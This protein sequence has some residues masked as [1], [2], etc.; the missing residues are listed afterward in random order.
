ME[1]L[2]IQH[3]QEV[4][5]FSCYWTPNGPTAA[6]RIE[7]F[8]GFLDGLEGAIKNMETTNH[9]L[10]I[11]GDFNAKSAHWGSTT[12]DRKGEAL[13][14]FVVSHG[15][16]ACNTGDKPTFQSGASSSVIDVTF[17]GERDPGKCPVVT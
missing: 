6:E 5:I 17:A 9:T 8:N 10:I 4:V 16:W 14:T 13:E 2:L 11:A 7:S 3:V 1:L 15:L 12:T